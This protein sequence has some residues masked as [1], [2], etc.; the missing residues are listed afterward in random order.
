MPT[1][2]RVA[3]PATPDGS[4]RLRMPYAP[5]GRP[6]AGC[7]FSASKSAD[8]HVVATLARW[9]G[10]LHAPLTCIRALS[11]DRPRC[12]P[13]RRVGPGG[14]LGRPALRQPY[15]LRHRT[16]QLRQPLQHQSGCRASRQ[17]RRG[18]RHPGDYPVMATDLTS[19]HHR[20]RR[21]R[22]A[23]SAA[24][25]PEHKY[26]PSYRCMA[27]PCAT[28]RSTRAPGRPGSRSPPTQ[29]HRP[30]HRESAGSRTTARHPEQHDP[31]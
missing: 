9:H 13:A 1:R 16:L 22:Q 23:S 29:F 3:A 5:G 7:R 25:V 4:T 17:R 19:A 6:H 31:Q 14:C 30:G 26:Q 12:G 2:P 8:R 20:S 10:G 21:P 15:R 27:R 24:A 18:D 11:S 28:S